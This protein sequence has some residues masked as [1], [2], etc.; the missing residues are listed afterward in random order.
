[1]LQIYNT[2]TRQKEQFKP[3]QP[4]KVGMYVCG[5][6]TYDY[7]HIGHARTYISFDV[8]ARYL[9]FSGYQVLFVRNITD[10]D[11]KIIKRANEQQVGFEVIV[12][13]Y[14]KAMHD[15]FAALDILPPDVE[16]RATTT[17][18]GIIAIT[19]QLIARNMAYATADGDVYYRVKKFPEYG[20]LSGQSLDDLMS[21]ARV[22][23]GEQKENPLD[24]A[25]WKSAKPNEPSWDSPWGKGRPG[26]HIECSAMSKACLGNTFDI[27]GGGSDLQFPHHE[28]EIAQSE[29]ANGCQFVRYWMH[30]GM[31][32]V[33]AVKMSKSLGNFF[34]IRDVLKA[35]SAEVIRFFLL[36]GHYRS[37]LNYSQDNLDAAK[38]AL[39][40]LYTALRGLPVTSK[41]AG[42]SYETRFREAMDDDFNVPEAIAVL[43][44]LVREINRLRANDEHAAAEHAAMFR[45]LAAVLGICQSDPE[46]FFKQGSDDEAE[47]IEAL[48]AERLAAKKA[49][50]FA[51]ADEIRKELSECGIVLEDSATGTT[52]KRV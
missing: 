47:E 40:R 32:Q 14:V 36:S 4:G 29:G 9:R 18:E 19:E 44:D 35:Y 13:T 1:M 30:S 10:I 3:L 27:H 48:I 12:D 49:K 28:N 45:R 31:V 6:T 33:D 25:L 20:R 22:E 39:A 5:V 43:F 24:F 42:E 23:V 52:W 15:D 7:C 46:S 26:W 34:T 38:N 50:N 11:D 17:I 41:L 37:Q 16:P 51:R 2:L 8:V 21:G